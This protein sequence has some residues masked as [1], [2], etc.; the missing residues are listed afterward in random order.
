MS[1][2]VY[3]GDE[4]GALVFDPGHF[5]FRCF[6]CNSPLILLHIHRGLA[7]TAVLGVQILT[8]IR[9]VGMERIP[10]TAKKRGPTLF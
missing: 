2:G 3:G 7:V 9:R 6:P 4:V 10:T 8:V 1:G 5:S